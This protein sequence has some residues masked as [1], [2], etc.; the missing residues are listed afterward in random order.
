MSRD[1]APE[2]AALEAPIDGLI[3]RLNRLPGIEVATHEY[4]RGY[5]DLEVT[6]PASK[7]EAA[8]RFC[9]G[10]STRIGEAKWRSKGDTVLYPRCR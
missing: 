6:F 1:E 4:A 8:V 2:R 9:V 7:A 10:L 5:F 3:G